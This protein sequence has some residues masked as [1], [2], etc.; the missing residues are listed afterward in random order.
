[1]ISTSEV[2]ISLAGLA[3]Q[4]FSLVVFCGLFA[5]YLTTAKSSPSWH[6]VTKRLTLFLVFLSLSILFILYRCVYRIV[7]LHGG[8]FSD[9]FRDE[10]L[11]IANESR[12]VLPFI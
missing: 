5:D 12:Y 6:R 3:F 7:E 2:N 9:T 11:F 1:M 4:V 10:P 8:Y